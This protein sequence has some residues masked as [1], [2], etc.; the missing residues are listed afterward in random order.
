MA[1]TVEMA[2]EA[3]K[4]FDAL[5]EEKKEYLTDLDSAIGDADHGINMNRGMKRVMDKIRDKEYADF[6]GIFRDAGMTVMSAVGGSAGP[7]YGTFFMKLGQKLSGKSEVSAGEFADAI[8][9]GLAGITSLGKSAVGDKTMVD[10]IDPAINALRE[11]A[12]SGDETAWDRAVAA[13][14]NGMKETIPMLARRGRS[15]YLGER[16]IGHQDPGATSAFYFLSCLRD[17]FRDGR[18][19][20]EK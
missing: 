4:K 7:L 11:N 19:S 20:G 3:L 13:A 6:S 8:G 5:V 9:E 2:R 14:E 10:A 15:S 16:S 12:S 17:A 18:E 1:F